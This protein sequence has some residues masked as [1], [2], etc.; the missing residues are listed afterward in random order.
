MQARTGLADLVPD[1]PIVL[2]R[3]RLRVHAHRGTPEL[4]A[5]SHC[6]SHPC[7]RACPHRALVAYDNGRVEL[8]EARCTGCG[9]CVAACTTGDIWR[10]PSLDVATKCD[11][12]A[13][14]G[15]VAACVV[16]C[17]SGALSLAVR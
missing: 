10:I 14:I 6:T 9:Y 3:R 13:P 11:G 15:G 4:H 12:C 17:P 1:A 5:C 7:T 2:E 16:A 8:F